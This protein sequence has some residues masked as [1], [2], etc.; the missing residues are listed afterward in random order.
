MDMFWLFAG[1][2]VLVLCACGG[3]ALMIAA[4]AYQKRTQN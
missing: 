4:M 3:V 1:I 2:G